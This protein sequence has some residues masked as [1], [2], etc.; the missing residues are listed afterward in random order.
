MTDPSL[1]VIIAFLALFA[2]IVVLIVF[3][4]SEKGNRKEMETELSNADAHNLALKASLLE[5]RQKNE[6]LEAQFIEFKYC[7]EHVLLAVIH[8]LKNSLLGIKMLSSQELAGGELRP[9][10]KEI[11]QY[12]KNSLSYGINSINQIL[13]AKS[14]KLIISTFNL[15][16]VLNE[17][18]NY[19]PE[20]ILLEFSKSAKAVEKNFLS[21]PEL[22]TLTLNNLLDNAIKHKNGDKQ[23]KLAVDLIDDQWIFTISNQGFIRDLENVF[24]KP[25]KSSGGDN[26]GIGSFLAKFLT[27]KLGGRIELNVQD[28]FVNV[29][30]YIPYIKQTT[31]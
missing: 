3:L 10:I 4:V 19:Q 21:N 5:S 11:N 24:E 30:V 13:E 8:D 7:Q 29:T 25:L 26:T 16:E 14:A 6:E 15:A 1:P 27:N 28:N 22:L 17:V 12:A 23:V 18:I 20:R 2:A 9:V 31:Y